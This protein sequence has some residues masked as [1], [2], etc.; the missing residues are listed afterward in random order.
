MKYAPFAVLAAILIAV[1][2][3]ALGSSDENTKPVTVFFLRHAEDADTG[4]NPDPDLTEFGAERADALARL[5][6]KSGVTHFYS[7]EYARTQSTL[8]PL[9]QA[10]GTTV[11]IV[12]ARKPAEQ[13]EKLRALPPGAVAIVAGHSNTIPNL[14][15]T[16]G[17]ELDELTERGWIE[18]PVHDRIFIV[19]LQADGDTQTV[20]LR[21]GAP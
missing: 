9:A 14:I 18:E 3:P 5:L 4:G 12:S 13:I 11:E 8:R 7:S 21:Y 17:G 6:S 10:I 1:T 15:K 2:L 19:T 20:E 16:L